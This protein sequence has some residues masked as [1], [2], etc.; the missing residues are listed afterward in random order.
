MDLTSVWLHS[1]R[2]AI[3]QQYSILLAIETF[4]TKLPI[5]LP[6]STYALIKIEENN[7]RKRDFSQIV[8]FSVSRKISALKE[9][10]VN[11]MYQANTTAITEAMQ[12]LT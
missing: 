6:S 7:E 10:S 8:Q 5:T 4:S 12:K 9:H 3:H 2:Y 1:I 11:S